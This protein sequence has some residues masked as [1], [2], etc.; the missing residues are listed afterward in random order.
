MIARITIELPFSLTIPHNEEFELVSFK[1]QDYDIC[2]HPLLHSDNVDKY[3]DTQEVRING[4][5]T[6]NAN[7]LHIVFRKENFDR[8]PN[9]VFE[10]PLELIEKVSNDFLVGLR[11]VLSADDIKKI[12]VGYT[13]VNVQYLNDDGTELGVNPSLV[14]SRASIITSFK[15]RALTK[16]VWNNIHSLNDLEIEKWRILLLDSSSILPEI[17]PSIVLTFTALEVFI[18]T[19]LDKLASTKELDENL[20]NWINNR[21]FFLKNPSIEEQFNFLCK[22]LTGSTI[23]E[24]DKLWEAFKNLQSARN[25]FAHSG[26]AKIGKAEVEV[27]EAKARDFIN[28]AHEMINYI[29]VNLPKEIQWQEFDNTDIK[30]EGK[31]RLS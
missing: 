13:N 28:K 19:I 17:G 23:K 20:W 15:V 29:K 10:P 8:T 7:V 16:K 25:S 6:Y 30:I 4:R 2:F 14:R 22:Y 11:Y 31:I 5:E 18:S 1:Y 24:N 3:S 9:G 12:Y 26:V 21:G 27:D